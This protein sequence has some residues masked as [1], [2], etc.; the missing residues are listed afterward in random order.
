MSEPASKRSKLTDEEANQVALSIVDMPLEV[1]MSMLSIMDLR[2]IAQMCRVNASFRSLCGT[3]EIK[4]IVA[5]LAPAEILAPSKGGGIA[6]ALIMRTPDGTTTIRIERILAGEYE[7]Q[8]LRD[9][10]MGLGIRV[11]VQ[12]NDPASRA[13]LVSAL[14]RAMYPNMRLM[15]DVGESLMFM[16]VKEE[17]P[18]PGAPT[19]RDLVTR[20]TYED[21]TR[22]LAR[23]VLFFLESYDMVLLLTPGAP[24]ADKFLTVTTCINCGIEARK[25]CKVTKTPYCSKRCQVDHWKRITKNR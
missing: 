15:F 4:R 16:V 12:T 18:V 17:L 22:I 7:R 20:L 19:A 13:A 14:T 6:P 1:Q 3:N 21:A 25:R 10:S 9:Y 24:A 2:S 23:L 5:S 8:V 11:T